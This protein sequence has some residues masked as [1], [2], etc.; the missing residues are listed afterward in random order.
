MKIR[1]KIIRTDKE[2]NRNYTKLWRWSKMC[3]EILIDKYT[4]RKKGRNKDFL[5]LSLRKKE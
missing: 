3:S 4:D 2:G 5:T 1:K